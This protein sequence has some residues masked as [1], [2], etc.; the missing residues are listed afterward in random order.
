MLSVFLRLLALVRTAIF[1][2]P[3]A[4]NR[5]G[6]NILTKSAQSTTTSQAIAF[7]VSNKHRRGS[8]PE[9]YIYGRIEITQADDKNDEE[10]PLLDFSKEKDSD[11]NDVGS[12]VDR[13]PSV[14]SKL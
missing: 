4:G 10:M 5:A 11:D 13:R 1:K 14:V 9:V 6:I 12:H 8:I 2:A 7:A 3:A